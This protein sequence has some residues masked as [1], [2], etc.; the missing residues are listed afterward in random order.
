[1]SARI[2]KEGGWGYAIGEHILKVMETLIWIVSLS[3]I[4]LILWRTIKDYYPEVDLELIIFWIRKHM[5]LIP[6]MGLP[7][8]TF[9]WPVEYS[10][11]LCWWPEHRKQVKKQM[12]KKGQGKSLSPDTNTHVMEQSHCQWTLEPASQMKMRHSSERYAGQ[13]EPISFHFYSL[14][15]LN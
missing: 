8:L 5:K 7:G 10:P 15:D 14:L 12:R 9:I 13:H 6:G 2:K 3:V 11:E 4:F 1:M